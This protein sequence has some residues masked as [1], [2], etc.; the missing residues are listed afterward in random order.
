MGAL[1]RFLQAATILRVEQWRPCPECRGVGEHLDPLRAPDG[2]VPRRRVIARIQCGTCKGKKRILMNEE[3][4]ERERPHQL[5][6]Y[7]K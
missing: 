2:V 7:H 4:R 6:I 3:W 5:R 1:S